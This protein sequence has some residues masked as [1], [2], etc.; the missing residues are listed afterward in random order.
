M[1]AIVWEDDLGRPKITDIP[2]D[3]QKQAEEFRAK[4]V[5]KSPIGRELTMKFLKPRKLALKNLGCLA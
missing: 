1:K 5:E 2:A 4:M 3:M